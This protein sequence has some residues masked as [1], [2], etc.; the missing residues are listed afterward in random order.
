MILPPFLDPAV[1][2][3]APVHFFLRLVIAGLFT[4]A[5]FA[6]QWFAG[7]LSD[8]DKSSQQHHSISKGAV[9]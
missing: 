4:A 1:L 6:V 5:V 2:D 7:F 3:H 9:R 8:R